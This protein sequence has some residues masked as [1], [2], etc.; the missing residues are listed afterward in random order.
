MSS[1][2]YELET[3]IPQAFP[4]GAGEDQ[5]CLAGKTMT[6]IDIPF[7]REM[8]I[9]AIDGY[10]IAT[11]RSEK[12]GEIGDIFYIDEIRPHLIA[13]QRHKPMFRL[14]DVRYTPLL[15]VA[16]NYYRLEGFDSPEAF[17]K[18]WRALHRGHFTTG[19]PYHIHFFGRVI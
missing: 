2:G 9:A 10:K 6:E 3:T 19:K 7:S 17:E 16:R 12:K 13:Q 8:A 5:P 4:S 14:I 11:T 1:I 15:D 18:T